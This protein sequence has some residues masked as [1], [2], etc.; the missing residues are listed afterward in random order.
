M[1]QP[2]ALNQRSLSSFQELFHTLAIPNISALSGTYRGDFVGPGW[3]RA[4]A[5]PALIVGGLPGWWGKWFDGAG[6]GTNLLQRGGSMQRAVPICLE[7]RPSLVDSR[8]GVTVV[9][10][11]SS[12]WPLPL[13]VDELRL[14]GDEALLGMTMV[15]R[16]SL[17]Q[18]SFPFLLQAIRE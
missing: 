17:Q 9:Y 7:I 3:V 5:G 6:Q 4:L 8:S 10:P 16:F 1:Y 15:S 13:I 14:L 12:P 18:F 11:G 2:A